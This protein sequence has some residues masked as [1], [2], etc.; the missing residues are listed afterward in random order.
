M[1]IKTVKLQTNKRCD[2]SYQAHDCRKKED[3]SKDRQ[4]W[5]ITAVIV[6]IFRKSMNKKMK[7]FY[8]LLKNNK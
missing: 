7:I 4:N 2:L 3:W 5:R 8:G 6:C 1:L